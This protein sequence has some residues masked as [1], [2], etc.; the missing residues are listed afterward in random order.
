MDIISINLQISENIALLRKTRDALKVRAEEKAQANADYEKQLAITILKLRN[1]QP[2]EIEGHKITDPPVSI[3]EKVAKGACYKE[4]I[5]KDIAEANY[6]NAVL[7]LQAIQSI[8]NALQS[9][10]KYTEEA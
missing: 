5:A 4:S 10:L 8:I 6:K 2:I 3:L 1:G 7:G 9:M